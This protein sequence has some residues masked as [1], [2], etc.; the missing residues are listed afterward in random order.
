MAVLQGKTESALSL[1]YRGHGISLVNKRLAGGDTS[2]DT[3][4]AIALLA[5]Y[6]VTQQ[7]F[8]RAK[9]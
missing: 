7:T 2:N 5:G 1:H 6:E 8:W 3:L 4:G 9:M